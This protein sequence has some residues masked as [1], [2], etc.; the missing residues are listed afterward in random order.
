[1]NVFMVQFGPQGIRH[2]TCD[3]RLLPCCAMQIT[4]HQFT[5]EFSHMLQVRDSMELQ[6]DKHNGH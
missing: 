5:S 4:S 2:F 6:Q 3:T 1:M